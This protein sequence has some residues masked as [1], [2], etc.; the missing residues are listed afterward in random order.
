MS[1][2]S[3]RPAEPVDDYLRRITVS[4][5]LDEHVA[6]IIDGRRRTTWDPGVPI[7]D[8]VKAAL[9]I[10]Y[11]KP[12][13]LLFSFK[14]R[15]GRKRYWLGALLAYLYFFLVPLPL[16]LLL[17]ADWL[18]LWVM[19]LLLATYMFLAVA[20]KRLHDL[21]LSGWWVC[22]Q[23]A[24]GVILPHSPLGEMLL[25]V[26]PILLGSWRGNA[27]TNQFGYPQELCQ[28]TGDRP[29]KPYRV[30]KHDTSQSWIEW[31]QAWINNNRINNNRVMSARPERAKNE[32]PYFVNPLFGVHNPTVG[33][34]CIMVLITTLPLGLL[35]V[36][37]GWWFQHGWI[38]VAGISAVF[39]IGELIRQI[40]AGEISFSPMIL[41][42]IPIVMVVI[43][44]FYFFGQWLGT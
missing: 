27:E 1:L 15:I 21:N 24:L 36:G 43:T 42:S 4:G 40:R 7:K 16:I 3:P 10:F 31:D 35:S 19:T 11:W 22:L 8:F 32:L 30:I 9:K 14:G 41:L 39:V 38:G 20:V 25:F 34:F 18:V 26:P 5:E 44:P 37:L 29:N 33:K 17:Q 6:G 23:I 2:P 12:S 13:W 28:Q